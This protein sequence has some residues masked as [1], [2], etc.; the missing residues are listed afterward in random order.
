MHIEPQKEH[1]WLQRLVGDWTFEGECD[2]GPDQPR[3][4]NTGAERVHAVGGLWTVGEGEGPT[5]DGGAMTSKMTLGYDPQK[6]KFVGTFIAS[7]MSNLWIYE[8]SLDAAGKVLTLDAE[9]PSF[10]DD[11]T[12]MKYQDR[13]EFIDN[14]HRTLRSQVLMPDGKW[15]EFMVAHY[16]RT[17]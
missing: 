13:I 14:D 7:M 4:K 2:M 1:R 6:Q 11:G 15:H 5:P 9:G 8:G 10:I 3:M 16:K 17:T 12:L